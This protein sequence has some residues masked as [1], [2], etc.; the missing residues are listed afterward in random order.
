ML[1]F[2]YKHRQRK[3]IIL[4]INDREHVLNKHDMLILLQTNEDYDLAK[5]SLLSQ[6]FDNKIS[7]N[8]K[9]INEE[10]VYV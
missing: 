5:Q 10:T 3:P 4:K 8:Y 1:K 6:L 2:T 7:I 9:N